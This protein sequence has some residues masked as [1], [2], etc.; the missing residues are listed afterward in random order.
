MEGGALDAA[1]WEGGKWAGEA[2]SSGSVELLFT[3]NGEFEGGRC[4][5]SLLSGVNRHHSQL[6]LETQS[7][8]VFQLYI[9]ET[10]VN[11][12]TSTEAGGTQY[13]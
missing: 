11:P 5:D 8:S 10:S 4:R 13:L 12:L 3:R 9:T 7:C 2:T 6:Q 1:V